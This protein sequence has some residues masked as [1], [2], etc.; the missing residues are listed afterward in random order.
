MILFSYPSSIVI[1]R[2]YCTILSHF[3]VYVNVRLYLNT[4][5]GTRK[6]IVIYIGTPAFSVISQNTFFGC[7]S[8]HQKARLYNMSFMCYRVVSLTPDHQ[9]AG[10]AASSLGS[11]VGCRVEG[12][13]IDTALGQ[14]FI[15]NSSH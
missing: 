4:N 9:Y 6:L 10:A 7:R 11:A 1:T 3:L 5:I 13:A 8:M 2:D 14:C 15:P 12:R